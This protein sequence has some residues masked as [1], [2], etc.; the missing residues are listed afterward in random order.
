MIFADALQAELG[1]DNHAG[2]LITG[3]AWD[4]IYV[5]DLKAPTPKLR[6]CL[7]SETEEKCAC[8]SCDLSDELMMSHVSM[9]LIM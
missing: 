6:V 7:V 3:A 5:V 1:K 4:G 8:W 2:V 9:V